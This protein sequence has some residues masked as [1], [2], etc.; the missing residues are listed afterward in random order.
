M[1]LIASLALGLVLAAAAGGSPVAALPAQIDDR[2]APA[3]TALEHPCI[4]Q[5]GRR[6]LFPPLEF[7]FNKA[8]LRP[9]S[10]PIL[11]ELA[12]LILRHPELGRLE[13]QNHRESDPLKSWQ[14]RDITQDRAHEVQR[15]LIKHAVPPER[16]IAKGYGDSR[17][18]VRGR[19]PLNRRTEILIVGPAA[20]CPT[21]PR[22]HRLSASDALEAPS[23]QPP[24]PRRRPAG[25][26]VF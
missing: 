13:I 19:S 11:V 7:E 20:R 6:L 14:S 2:C 26:P 25:R 1:V 18:L 22:R 5:D 4:D 23:P 24:H 9:K 16:L 10:L 3:A 17:P 8:K 21:A 15:E 12:A